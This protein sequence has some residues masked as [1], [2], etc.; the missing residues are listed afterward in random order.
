MG[1]SRRVRCARA[2]RDSTEVPQCKIAYSSP[3]LPKA[4]NES[5][6][7]KTSHFHGL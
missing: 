7:R 6:T 3:A 5:G 2:V 1:S 4:T